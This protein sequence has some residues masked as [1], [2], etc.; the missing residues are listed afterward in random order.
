MKNFDLN[1]GGL[2][3]GLALGGITGFVVFNDPD[4][5]GNA[6][7]LAILALIIG[8]FAGNIVWGLI[9]RKPEERAKAL[10][11]EL[12]GRAA[13]GGGH[14][15]SAT[16]SKWPIVGAGL[17]LVAALIVEHFAIGVFLKARETAHWPTAKAT[18]TR[19]EMKLEPGSNPK[20]LIEY[21]YAVG[22]QSYQSNRL[23]TRGNTESDRADV[24]ALIEKYPVASEVTAYYNPADPAE[25]FLES[26]LD[27]GNYVGIISPLVFA[28]AAAAG[29]FSALKQNSRAKQS[30]APAR[31]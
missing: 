8:A 3:G 11:N 31:G 16:G 20:A 29:L 28:A 22:E 5:A 24:T 2:I 23:R 14:V 26:G 21:T 9:F 27:G 6:G 4:N 12:S 17:L 18:I 19:S 25:A 13:P 1:V 15:R 7:R 30:A 10:V